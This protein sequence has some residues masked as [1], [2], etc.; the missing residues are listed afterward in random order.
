MTTKLS[1]ELLMH[2]NETKGSEPS[3]PIPVIIT[4]TEG[5]DLTE[6]RQQGLEIQRIFESISAVSGTL[7]VAEI[8][9]IA[10]SE[11]VVRVEFD[12]TVFAYKDHTR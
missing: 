8:E 12:G 9:E 11:Q 3:H 6:L 10:K 7:T 1:D 4:L 5:S 2:L